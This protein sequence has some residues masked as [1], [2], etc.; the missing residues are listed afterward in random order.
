MI[1]WAYFILFAYAACSKLFAYDKFLI[2]MSKSAMLTPYAG[3]LA[4][5]VPLTEIVLAL[6]LMFHRFRQIALYGSFSLMIMFSTYI[7]LVLYFTPE[8]PCGCGAAIEAI[9]WK[10]HLVLNI[11]FMALAATGLI[12]KHSIDQYESG[13]LPKTPHQTE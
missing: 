10:W 5:A 13:P 9:G 2:T 1:C 4:W 12:I 8:V 7:V 6:L 3:L 11:F